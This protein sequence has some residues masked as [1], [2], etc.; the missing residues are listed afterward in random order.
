MTLYLRKV[1]YNFQNARCLGTCLWELTLEW[2]ETSAWM[3]E[4]SKVVENL[5]GKSLLRDGEAIA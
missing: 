1:L 4:R 5:V 2:V 3:R